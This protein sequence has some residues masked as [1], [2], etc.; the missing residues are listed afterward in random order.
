M[1][2]DPRPARR[3]TVTPTNSLVASVARYQVGEAERIYQPVQDWQREAY[4]HYAICGEARFAAL[5]YGN[6]LSRAVIGVA[7]RDASRKVVPITTG[8][9]VAYLDEFF[10]GT[11]GQGQLL[12]AMGIHLKI[13]GECWAVGRV[14]KPWEIVSVLEMNVN[15]SR[16]TVEYGDGKPPVEL[17]NGKDVVIRIWTPFPGKR[18]EAD[19]PFRSMIPVLS[20][21]EWFTRHIFAQTSSRLAG[22]GLL[23]LPESATFPPPPPVNGQAQ[24][25][26]DELTGIMRTLADAM[27]TPIKD[28]SNAAAMV[29][30]VAK[31]PDEAVDKIKL[32]HF[33]SN[34][35]EKALDMRRAAIERFAD[36]FDLPKEL[37]RGMSSNTGTGGGS[38]NGVS[39]WGQWQIEEQGIKLHI[40]PMLDSIVNALTLAY[41]RPLTKDEAFFTYDTAALRLRPDK[42]KESLELYDRGLV[43]I[44]V[45]LREHGFDPT[46]DR[47]EEEEFKRWLLVKAATS[48]TTPEQVAQAMRQLGVALPM[49]T[50]AT[51]VPREERPPPSLE[52]HPVR[53][54][55][56][57][58]NL[59]LLPVAESLVLR[60]LE[61]A[62]NRI[63]G[64]DGVTVP[65]V[66]AYAMHTVHA[67]NGSADSYLTDAWSTAPIVL[68]GVADTE[69][70]VQ[71]LNAYC[72]SLMASQEPHT[73]ERLQRFLEASCSA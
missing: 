25:V 5:Y 38:S 21:I 52:Q 68:D 40:E 23:L 45:V 73:R 13:A 27:L 10:A 22:A 42:S 34:L 48:S 14:G 20:E 43:S 46:S 71:I 51:Q 39:H 18:N 33:W 8:Q 4:R 41:L 17:E 53:P 65:G 69:R 54:R 58:E 32:L 59:A 15:G 29:P 24:K 6:A 37:V 61:R 2:R 26:N 9:H 28:P 31:V 3:E 62:G 1:P 19:S 55:T 56:P 11:V 49:P 72:R 67:C 70:T 30:L 60:A 7:K 47:M 50:T 57:G 36:G 44:E 63:R 12:E 35:D 64:R 66:P 16:W